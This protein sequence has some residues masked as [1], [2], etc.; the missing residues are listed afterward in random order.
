MIADELEEDESVIRGMVE[1]IQKNFD[2]ERE[3][4]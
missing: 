3:R 2:S 4:K 1:K